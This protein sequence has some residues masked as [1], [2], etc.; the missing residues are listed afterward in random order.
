MKRPLSRFPWLLGAIVL[1]S[2]GVLWFL[3]YYQYTDYMTWNISHATAG[4]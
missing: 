1:I 4:K 3:E 2:G